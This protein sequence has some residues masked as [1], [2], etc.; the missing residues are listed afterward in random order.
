MPENTRQ[1]TKAAAARG[2]ASPAVH[3]DIDVLTQQLTD[4]SNED[5]CAGMPNLINDAKKAKLIPKDR[6][7][8]NIDAILLPL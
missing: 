7:V 6:S 2:G 3:F 8:V 1:A 5:N 4:M